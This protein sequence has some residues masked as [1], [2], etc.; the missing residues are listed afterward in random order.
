MQNSHDG[1]G[2]F[3]GQAVV[4]RI[5]CANTAQIADLESTARGTEFTFRHTKNVADRI[6][7]AKDALAGWRQSITAWQETSRE[8]IRTSITADQRE[9]F[10]TSFIPMP[11][12]HTISDLVEQNVRKARNQLR[13]ILDGPTCE[14]IEFTTYGLTQ[15]SIEY[16]NHARRARSQESR[17]KRTYLDRSDILADAVAIARDVAHV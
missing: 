7:Q 10:I 1:S 11:P 8:M 15:A 4:E 5:V 3:R 12:P 16:L 2:A 17:F 14:G 13:A 9:Q 6:E